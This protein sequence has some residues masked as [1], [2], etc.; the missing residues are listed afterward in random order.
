MVSIEGLDTFDALNANLLIDIA[1]NK[2]CRI[3]PYANELINEGWL[4]NRARYAYDG[5]FFQRLNS[6]LLQISTLQTFDFPGRQVVR[7]LT[8]FFI[9]LS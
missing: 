8:N 1:A 6:C 3:L 4:T 7:R 9:K 5:L 2:I